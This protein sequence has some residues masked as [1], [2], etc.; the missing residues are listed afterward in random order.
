MHFLEKHHAQFD[1]PIESVHQVLKKVTS[2]AP[3]KHYKI[4][5]GYDNEVFNVEVEG[6]QEFV[7][8]INQVPT[9]GFENERRAIDQCHQ[10]GLPVP[11][12]LY[13]G[14]IDSQGKLLDVMI[15]PKIIGKTMCDGWGKYSDVQREQLLQQMG[16]IMR[17]MHDIDAGGFRCRQADEVWDYNNWGEYMNDVVEQSVTNAKYLEEL[18]LKK[19][20]IAR[21]LKL[22]ELLRDEYNE[23]SPVMCHADLGL[24][25]FFVDEGKIVGLIDFGDWQGNHPV[26]DFVR[27][28]IDDRINLQEVLAGYGDDID[29]FD[30]LLALYINKCMIGLTKHIFQIKDYNKIEAYRN[31]FEKNLENLS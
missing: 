16:E 29:N 24:S 30:T 5:G 11:E 25:H 21:V 15:Q 9:I 27:L 1:T 2:R 19:E 26:F 31:I 14:K 23:V 10:A 13:L 17:K 22:V 3:I 20:Q 7:V 18:G 4:I 8:R 12:V 6:G 28:A